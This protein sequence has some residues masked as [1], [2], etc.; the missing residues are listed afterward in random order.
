MIL[1][2]WF[3]M[4]I[5][6]TRTAGSRSLSMHNLAFQ[7]YSA[8]TC[9]EVLRAPILQ[10][11][12]TAEQWNLRRRDFGCLEK[13][14]S[15]AQARNGILASSFWKARRPWIAFRFRKRCSILE[16][17]VQCMQL[18][19]E[20]RISHSEFFVSFQIDLFGCSNGCMPS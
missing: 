10:R 14:E 7:R 8:T 9:R 1:R 20:S 11:D 12:A 3:L 4:M 15:T 19:C 13:C 17:F 2:A 18:R 6:K 5:F 16:D